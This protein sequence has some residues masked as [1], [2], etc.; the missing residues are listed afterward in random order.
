MLKKTLILSL[1]LLI[2]F[3]GRCTRNN[4]VKK[5]NQPVN[6]SMYIG[7]HDYSCGTIS[8]PASINQDKGL[9][10]ITVTGQNNVPPFKQRNTWIKP[11]WDVA[12]V[13]AENDTEVTPNAFPNHACLNNGCVSFDVP[14]NDA[15]S[16]TALYVEYGKDN[17]PGAIFCSNPST[18]TCFRWLK[19]MIVP[20]G[21]VFSCSQSQYNMYIDTMD[22]NGF[23]GPCN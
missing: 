4:D 8:P 2:T 22:P 9:L 11:Y 7:Q 20:A 13:I 14:K 16:I 19:Q 12:E 6:V 17:K 15:F 10:R 3:A 18:G 1:L 5:A 21:T 23:A